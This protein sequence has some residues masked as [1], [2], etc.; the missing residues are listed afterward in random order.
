M[1]YYKDENDKVYA[2][3][4]LQVQ[5]GKGSD[6]TSITEDE[7]DE[8]LTVTYT[9]DELAEI[10]YNWVITELSSADAM[11]FEAQDGDLLD[12]DDE[13]ISEEYVRAYKRALRAYTSS[14]TDDDDVT[15]YTVNALA[16]Y[17]AVDDVNYVVATDDDTGRPVSP[18]DDGVSLYVEPTD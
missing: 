4:D 11:Q 16:D 7:K 2:F 17:Y 8:L 3:N 10:E 12:D 14:S 1:N 5:Q 15:T 6:L 9:D 18:E 13:E